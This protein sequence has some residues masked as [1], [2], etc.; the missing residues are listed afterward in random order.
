VAA[1]HVGVD[2]FHPLPGRRGQGTFTISQIG[3]NGIAKHAVHFG[4]GQVGGGDVVAVVFK[5]KTVNGGVKA[6]VSTAPREQPVLLPLALLRHRSSIISGTRE[7]ELSTV[8]AQ[9]SAAAS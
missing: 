3:A 8:V 2:L 4:G 7:Q 6:A 1:I 9:A 5:A